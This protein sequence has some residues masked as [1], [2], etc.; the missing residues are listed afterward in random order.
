MCVEVIVDRLQRSAV[1]TIT[2]SLCR[3]RDMDL[4]ILASAVSASVGGVVRIGEVLFVC[5]D[6]F[7][8]PEECRR[9]AL[10]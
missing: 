6:A 7:E 8:W 4:P 10:N 9:F 5:G 1:I 3:P 2:V